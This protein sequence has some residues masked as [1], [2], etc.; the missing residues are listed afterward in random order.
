MPGTFR[1]REQISARHFSGESV[2]RKVVVLAGF[3]VGERRFGEISWH[4]K[5]KDMPD[6]ERRPT[7]DVVLV[8]PVEN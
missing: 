7:I 6:K 4:C 2:K 5:A 8:K 1:G 3:S